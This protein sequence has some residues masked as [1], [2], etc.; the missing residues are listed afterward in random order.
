MQGGVYV[1]RAGLGRLLSTRERLL[2][3]RGAVAGTG[4][5]SAAVGAFTYIF[6]LVA[7]TFA[8]SRHAYR[9]L[10]EKVPY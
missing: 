6:Q 4:Q 10:L 2:P 9:Y 8:G 3:L 7:S 1:E 5:R